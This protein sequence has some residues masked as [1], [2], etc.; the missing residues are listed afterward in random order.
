MASASSFAGIE[1]EPP[2]EHGEP[3]GRRHLAVVLVRGAARPPASSTCRRVDELAEVDPRRE[4]IG[5]P[6]AA[7]PRS[8]APTL[9]LIVSSGSR[10]RSKRHQRVEEVEEHG[11]VGHGERLPLREALVE[12]VPEAHRGLPVLP[13]QVDRLAPDAAAG[14]RPAPSRGPSSRRPGRAISSSAARTSMP[15]PSSRSALRLP[16]ALVDHAR[17]R[18]PGCAPAPRARCSL[19]RRRLVVVRPWRA[20][21]IVGQPRGSA[22][23]PRPG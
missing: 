3:L 2:D 15:S 22:R 6:R 7:A 18:T 10:V 21:T 9:P 8:S 16:V 23:R 14:S 11:A 4:G 12:P 17:R 5:T 1:A 13:A 20:P 19:E